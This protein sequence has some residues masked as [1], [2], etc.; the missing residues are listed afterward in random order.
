[1]GGLEIPLGL[2]VVVAILAMLKKQDSDELGQETLQNP[3]DRGVVQGGSSLGIL[4]G[5]AALVIF[6]LISIGGVG[7]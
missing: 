2:I 1:M 6:A 5:L 3:V 7:G 4:L